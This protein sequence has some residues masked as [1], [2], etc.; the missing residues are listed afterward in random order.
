MRFEID[1]T[2]DYQR[3]VYNN[4]FVNFVMPNYV[5]VTENKWEKLTI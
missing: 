3:L 5:H 4:R 1:F 2:N